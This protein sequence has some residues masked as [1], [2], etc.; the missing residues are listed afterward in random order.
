MHEILQFSTAAGQDP[1]TMNKSLVKAGAHS[2]RLVSMVSIPSSTRLVHCC[3]ERGHSL[4]AKQLR[5]AKVL[6]CC[7]RLGSTKAGM[8]SHGHVIACMA[9]HAIA[10]DYCPEMGKVD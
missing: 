3:V 9:S 10:W 1:L 5:C 4:P 7:A 6:R 8:Q 2:F